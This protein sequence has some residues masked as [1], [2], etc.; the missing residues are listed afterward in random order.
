MAVATI[1]L[2]A[3]APEKPSDTNP[4]GGNFDSNFDANFNG[5]FDGNIE[6]LFL[7]PLLRIK[8]LKNRWVR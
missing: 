2:C 6:L 3:W 7:P 8:K 4:F 5:N 1:L